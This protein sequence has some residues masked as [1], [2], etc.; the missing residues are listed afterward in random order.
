MEVPGVL[1]IV[2]PF[3]GSPAEKA[4]LRGGDVIVKI[5]DLA[6]TDKLSLQDAVSRIKGPAG[7]EVTLS[8][9]RGN[10]NLIVKIKRERIEVKF[11]EYKKLPSGVAYLKISA[12]GNGTL[13]AF[14]EA[15]KW[16]DKNGTDTDKLII[17]LRNNPGGSL[18]E[19]GGILSY[20]VPKGEPVVKI[21]LR[22]SKDEMVSAGTA[23][24]ISS[25]KI[26]ILINGGSASASEIMAGTIKDYLPK[27]VLVGEKTYGKGSV[28]SFVPFPDGSS[29]KY[30]V[31]KWF[32]GKTETGI[33]HIG[34]SPDV[35]VPSSTGAVFDA[36]TADEVVAKAENALRN[37][38]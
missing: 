2:S 4:G 10:E 7:T 37:I 8:I 1:K 35:A 19:V 25:R 18:E 29:L 24:K 14:D 28:Q 17:D 12:F 38:R 26:A 22:D 16:I 30:T 27:T 21:R 23:S 34:I 11:V 33:D 32:T 31:A 9:K 3:P 13:A 36:S 5:G 6:V 20:F 15:A